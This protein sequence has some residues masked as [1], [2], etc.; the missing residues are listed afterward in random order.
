[1]MAGDKRKHSLACMKTAEGSP[2]MLHSLLYTVE[3]RSH[4]KWM[5]FL[6]VDPSLKCCVTDK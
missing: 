3:N 6:H 2:C 5:I 4:Q 1:M